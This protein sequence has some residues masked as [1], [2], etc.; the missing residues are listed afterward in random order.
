MKIRSPIRVASVV[1][2]GA[3][4]ALIVVFAI[5]KRADSPTAV[6]VLIFHTSSSMPDADGQSDLTAND[7]GKRRQDCV[8]SL[9]Q[10]SFFSEALKDSA[11]HAAVLNTAWGK[12]FEGKENSFE[13]QVDDLAA[14]FKAE[15]VPSSQLIRL[16]IFI[17]P[18]K[19]GVAILTALGDFYMERSG[20]Q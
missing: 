3:V 5:R 9:G 7:I 1:I 4:V 19:D 2:I 20:R 8:T 12:D 13:A 10:R 14:K 16:T 15:A 6:G 11:V 17:P 18:S